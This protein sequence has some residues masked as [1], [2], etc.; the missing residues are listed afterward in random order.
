[1]RTDDCYVA[2]LEAQTLTPSR[3]ALS[4][5][6]VNTYTHPLVAG[7][8]LASHP[9]DLQIFPSG[10]SSGAGS[11]LDNY[12]FTYLAPVGSPSVNV[13]VKLTGVND[14]AVEAGEDPVG[15]VWIRG[16]SVGALLEVEE[17][18]NVEDKGWVE[19]GER[20]KVL[21]NGTFKVARK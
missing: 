11:A 4:V 18:E 8:V 21:P 20:A 1:M 14:D 5:P 2:S 10:P 12:A 17:D 3:I 19:T 7:P 15:A 16:P 6:L 9:F 13:E